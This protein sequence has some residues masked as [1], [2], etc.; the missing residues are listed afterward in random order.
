MNK[1]VLFLLFIILFCLVI[2]PNVFA[3]DNGREIFVRHLDKQG[4]LITGLSNTSQEV[5]DS[6][7][8]SSLLTNSTADDASIAYSEYYEYPVSS[9]MEIT[10]SLVIENDSV[11]YTYA[12]YNVCTM[13]SLEEA[14][15]IMEQK[16]NG[17]KSGTSQLDVTYGN[18]SIN[19]RY[20]TIQSNNNDVTIIDFYYSPVNSDSIKPKLY[21]N[22][23]VWNGSNTGM[24]SNVTYVPSGEYLY[25]YFDTPSYAVKDLAYEKVITDGKVRYRVSKYTVYKVSRAELISSESKH[26]GLNG[27]IEIT[28]KLVSNSDPAAAIGGIGDVSPIVVKNQDGVPNMLENMVKNYNN[29]NSTSFPGRGELDEIVGYN[30]NQ[31]DY[32]ANIV[33]KGDALNGLRSAKGRVY[34]QEYNVLT[35]QT[36]GEVSFVSVNDHYINIYTPVKLNQPQ[37]TVT[38]NASIDHSTVNSS[39]VILADD[40][41]FEMQLSCGDLD[42][43]YYNNYC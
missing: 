29:S 42:F 43:T 34:Y 41:T 11:Q 22:T 33:I 24:I 1:K 13:P 37:V 25:P 16:R 19:N 12:G 6:N 7:E 40:A 2:S 26:L 20:S 39:T 14:Y 38:G 21:S 9:T 30:T 36:G 28:G 23:S 3:Y 18:H 17:I 35:G 10:K 31:S 5:I 32:D 8:N 15:A 27:Q 4:N